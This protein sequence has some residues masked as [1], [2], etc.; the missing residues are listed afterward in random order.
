MM[1]RVIGIHAN[2]EALNRHDE[3]ADKPPPPG[4]TFIS[5]L[6]L[7]EAFIHLGPHLIIFLLG[8]VRGVLIGQAE[9]QRVAHAVVFAIFNS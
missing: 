7:H 1:P 9:G 4:G 2:H 5:K 6:E 3:C 8:L